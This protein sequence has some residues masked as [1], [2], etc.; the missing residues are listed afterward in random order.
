MNKKILAVTSLALAASMMLSMAGC[1]GG[2]EDLIP[3]ESKGGEAS[4][5]QTKL[6]FLRA[7]T[8]DYKKEAFQEIIKNF[9]TANPGTT[10]EYQEAPWGDDMETK[11]N[12]GFASGTAADVINFSLASM[13]QRIPMGQ[14]ECLNDYTA[15]WEGKDDYYESVLQAGSVGD[16]LYGIGYLADARVFAYNTEL[17]EKAGLDPEKPPKTWEELKTYHE[18][19]IIKDADG[20]VTQSGFSLAT[21]GTGLNQ[22]LALFGYQNEVF[23][24]VDESNDEIL[25][26]SPGSI[27]AMS[28]LKELKDIG[29]IMWDA[30]KSDQNPFANG[31][32]GMAVTSENEYKAM[33][34]GALEGKIKMAPMFKGKA[35]GTFCGMH[36]M[37]MNAN[38]KAKDA[39]WNFIDFATSK[40][41]TQIW[42][43]K[44]GTPPLRKSQEAAYLEKNTENGQF[45]MDAVQTGRGSPK[46]AYSNTMFTIV[47]NA[48]EQIY[49]GESSVEDSLNAAAKKLQEEIDNQ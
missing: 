43:D 49:Y 33:N 45:I 35:E 11:L 39:A 44:V 24:L 23:N 30:T 18:K 32:A 22:M 16:K 9:E 36:F 13:G 1:S 7:G 3:A 26:N 15:D 12:T 41:S 14:Y 20:N 19:L 2:N 28:F 48:M 5:E 38:S 17:F 31:T 37:F 25:F 34:V 46:I 21:N 29:G 27:E 47:D 10:V 42:M 40:D 4:G 8:E 6:V